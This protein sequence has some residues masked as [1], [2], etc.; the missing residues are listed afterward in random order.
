MEVLTLISVKVT[1]IDALMSRRLFDDVTR[2]N[3]RFPLLVMCHLLMAVMDLPTKF[4]ADI[5]IQSELLTFFRNSRMR[6]PPSWIIKLCAFDTFLYLNSVVLE[7]C[8]KFRS[9]ICYSH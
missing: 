1:E 8:T 3:F 9:N 4:G 7:L 6:P 5:F 2:I